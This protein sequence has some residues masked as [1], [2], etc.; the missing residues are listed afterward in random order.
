MSVFTLAQAAELSLKSLARL[1]EVDD[2]F[3]QI[4]IPSVEHKRPQTSE[5]SSGSTGPL[6]PCSEVK[7]DP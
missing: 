7:I 5:P 6:K 3:A 4:A 1:K 2:R